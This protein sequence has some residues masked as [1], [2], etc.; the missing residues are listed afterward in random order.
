MKKSLLFFFSLS[1]L[2]LNAQS[3]DLTNEAAIGDAQGYFLCD[4][5]AVNYDAVVGDGIEWDYSAILGIP[6]QSRVVDIIDAS[7]STFY[8][9]FPGS[10]KAISI[11][12]ALT[13]FYSSDANERISQGFVFQEPSFG[14]VI[15]KWTNDSEKTH[16]YPMGLGNT[17][18]DVFDG[19]L[20]FTFNGI[21]QTPPC[22]GN[23]YAIVDGRG[24][25]KL[26][27][28]DYTNVIRYKMIDTALTNVILVGDL[29]VIRTQ[30]EYYDL[31]NSYMPLFIH[32]SIKI[33][34][35]GASQPLTEQTLVLSKDSPTQFVNTIELSKNITVYPVPANDYLI[36]EGDINTETT[37]MIFNHS[38]RII[39]EGDFVPGQQISLTSLSDGLYLLKIPGFEPISIV[40]K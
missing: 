3:L 22:N 16:A 25:L 24:T 30:Y 15:A 20:D 1:G 32:V 17:V 9:D 29:Q 39:M 26:P 23:V 36:I 27:G 4:S 13:T 40:K 31:A 34:T 2:L 14:D 6:N 21:P 37:Y 35:P 18:S 10:V 7:A 11:E 19:T 8:S 38:G 28:N 12:N 5:N 33:Q